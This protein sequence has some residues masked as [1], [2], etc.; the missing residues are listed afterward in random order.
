MTVDTSVGGF[1]DG[2]AEQLRNRIS[3]QDWSAW[4]V[5]ARATELG[6]QS[7]TIELVNE[8]AVR[9]VD[10]RFREIVEQAVAAAA[11]VPLQVTLVARA[12]TQEPPPQPP[13][14][15]LHIVEAPAEAAFLTVPGTAVQHLDRAEV[16]PAIVAA[17]QYGAA[18]GGGSTMTEAEL[19]AE[20]SM[21]NEIADVS[22]PVAAVEPSAGTYGRPSGEITVAR[23]SGE[24][25]RAAAVTMDPSF[26]GVQQLNDRYRFET[27]VIGPGNQM[28]H[29]AALSVAETPAQSY[30]PLF[31]H[32]P[33]GLGKTHLLHAIGHYVL[34]TRP[35]ARVA[36]VTTEQFLNRF[37]AAIQGAK[38][39]E[40]R[41]ARDQFKAF[42]R[43]VDVLL[44]D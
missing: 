24:P 43:E 10:G 30:N 7:I 1:W 44:M 39:P 4:F 33:T 37:Q 11:G 32:G 21:G 14:A 38:T 36:Y 3:S 35:E 26:T 20:L 34:E 27:F 41:D 6:P 2:I 28:V 18:S 13:S 23:A 31:V 29:A 16:V 15:P 17:V 12:S 42:F 8:F 9:W 5:G 25:V 22:L 19:R 40:G